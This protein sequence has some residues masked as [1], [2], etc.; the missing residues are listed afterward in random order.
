[1]PVI[2]RTKWFGMREHPKLLTF[3]SFTNCKYPK[4]L[5][6]G[7]DMACCLSETENEQVEN[8]TALILSGKAFVD[9]CVCRKFKTR[10][11]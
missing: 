8:K 1:M 11:M 4:P 9:F 5:W 6:F 7:Y 2:P 10:G 3:R